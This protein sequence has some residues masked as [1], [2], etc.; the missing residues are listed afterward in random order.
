MYE[1]HPRL[2]EWVIVE[3]VWHTRAENI[4]AVLVFKSTRTHLGVAFKGS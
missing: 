3:A 1:F 4:D 2:R